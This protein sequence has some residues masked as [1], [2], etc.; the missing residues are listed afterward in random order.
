[1]NKNTL[2]IFLAGIIALT[3]GVFFQYFYAGSTKQN[4]PVIEF[5]LPD[6][7][8]KEREITEWEGKI[9]VINFWATWCPPCLKEIPE[10]IKLQNEYKTK[11]VQFIGIAIDDQKAVEEYLTKIN[12]NYPTLIGG[13][14]AIALSHQLG[15]IVDA[16][17]F[18]VFFNQQGQIIHRQPGELD[19]KKFIEIV[20]PYL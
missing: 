9:R 10:F 16:V 5:S 19:R 18:T 6:L 12:I 17:P 15:N 11:N 3:G 2:Y 8:G 14:K 1:M 7:S 13:D 20:T 4:L